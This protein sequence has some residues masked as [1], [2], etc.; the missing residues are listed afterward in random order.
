MDP[1]RHLILVG[2]MGSGKTTVGCHL[3]RLCGRPFIDIDHEVEACAGQT[4]G[5]IFERHGEEEFRRLEYAMIQDV[6]GRPPAVVATGGGAVQ[7]ERNRKLLWKKGTVIYLQARIPSLVQRLKKSK[8][9]PLI[10]NQDPQAVLTA[11]LAKREAFYLQAHKVVVVDDLP[12]REVASTLW[13]DLRRTGPGKGAR[14][15]V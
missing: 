6:M 8:G 15:R 12:A 5:E 13:D 4:V 10:L 3:A 2:L 1:T 11:L 9:R 14:A 7:F